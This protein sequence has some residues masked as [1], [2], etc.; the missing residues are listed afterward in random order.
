MDLKHVTIN[1]NC[2][3]FEVTKKVNGP[4][5]TKR[6]FRVALPYPGIFQKDKPQNSCKKSPVYTFFAVPVTFC[7]LD[8]THF[9][10][11][12]QNTEINDCASLTHKKK[13]K[14]K[15]AGDDIANRF[16]PLVLRSSKLP[17]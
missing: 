8:I 16:P 14:K 11:S 4:L 1:S 13:K 3:H 10:A 15:D 5:K 6:V 9:R 2:S 12:V 17:L 7:G